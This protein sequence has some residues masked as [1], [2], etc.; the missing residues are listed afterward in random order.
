MLEWLKDWFLGITQQVLLMPVSLAAPMMILIG[1]LDSSLLSLPE[2]ND[3]I[4]VYR[5]AHQ[6]SEAW[7]FPLFPAAG[8][9]IGCL[10]LYGIARRGEKF[11]RRRFEPEHLETVQQLYR[12]WGAFALVIPALLPPPMPFKIFVAAAGAMNYPLGRFIVLVMI[13]RSIRYYAWAIAALIWREEVMS[14]LRFLEQNFFAV[15]AAALGLVAAIVAGRWIVVA[16][17]QR[18]SATR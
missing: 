15:L 9:V 2:V 14:V 13:A 12:R 10:V 4:T 1:A 11:I 3:Y 16:T 6:P 18:R 5:V 8:S 7:F 17:R